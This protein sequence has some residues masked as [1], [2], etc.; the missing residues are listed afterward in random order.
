M[1]DLLQA[2]GIDA[3]TTLNQDG[4]GGLVVPHATRD[5]HLL[6]A[7]KSLR[8]AV[9]AEIGVERGLFSE[10]IC[11]ALRPIR[12]HAV[13]AWTAYRGYREHVSQ[14]KL[15]GFMAEAASRLQ[16]YNATVH[17]G[18]SVDV[19]R[20]FDDGHLDFVYIDGNHTLPQVIADL[21]AWTPKVR[22]GGIIAGHD[23]GRA[24]VGHVREAVTAWTSAYRITP[25]FILAGDRSP[26][27]LWVQP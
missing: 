25:W 12:F 1:T 21:A 5:D 11:R 23:F 18:L 7:F 27:F 8:P 26:S 14:E 16:V 20:T 6:K 2:L 13:D 24:S 4:A 22:S 10:Q 3:S 17:R 9:G 15:D 19:A